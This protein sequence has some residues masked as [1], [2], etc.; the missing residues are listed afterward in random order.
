MYIDDLLPHAPLELCSYWGCGEVFHYKK[1]TIIDH[2]FFLPSTGTQTGYY[3]HQF[4]SLRN[5]QYVAM[6]ALPS[7][8]LVVAVATSDLHLRSAT[9]LYPHIQSDNHPKYFLLLPPPSLSLPPSSLFSRFIDLRMKSYQRQWRLQYPTAG[10]ATC[11]SDGKE[12]V[13]V[14]GSIGRV[15][16]SIID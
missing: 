3:I 12:H 4:T 5:T 15:G 10:K 16:T 6:T 9:L 7:P 14:V 11:T 1:T 2:Y 13:T 8:Q